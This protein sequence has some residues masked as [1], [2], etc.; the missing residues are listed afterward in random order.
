V[1][2]S[3]EQWS[4]VRTLLEACT[5]RRG[6]PQAS[7]RRVLEG[8]LWVLDNNEKWHHLPATF[9]PQQTCYNKWLAWRK[10]G[11]FDTVLQILEREFPAS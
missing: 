4:R 2:L 3:D 6:R 7:A 9:P 10:S 5:A 1:S 11:V 8:I